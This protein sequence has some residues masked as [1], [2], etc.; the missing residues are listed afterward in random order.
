MKYLL[1]LLLVVTPLSVRA[2]TLSGTVTDVYGGAI[3]KAYVVIRWDPVG[4]DGVRDKLGMTENKT[5]TTGGYGHFSVEVPAG[6]D[7]IFV[8]APGFAPHSE[9]IASKAKEN[10]PYEAR[11][12]VTRMLTIKLD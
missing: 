4:L 1:L 5:A 10:L 2:A 9:N 8:S 7:D 12:T 3:P 6:V 11:L